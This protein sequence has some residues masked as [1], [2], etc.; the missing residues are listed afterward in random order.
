MRL[1]FSEKRT[2]ESLQ[3]MT[4]LTELLSA[5][6]D[7]DAGYLRDALQELSKRHA[8][9]DIQVNEQFEAEFEPLLTEF[10]FL[11]ETRRR[12]ATN[13]TISPPKLGQPNT[14]ARTIV[15][16]FIPSTLICLAIVAIATLS[17]TTYV[18]SFAQKILAE[19]VAGSEPVKTL[20]SNSGN[21]NDQSDHADHIEK[22]EF[23]GV[24]TTAADKQAVDDSVQKAVGPQ[25]DVKVASADIRLADGDETLSLAQQYR[26]KAVAAYQV[27]DLRLALTYFDL[28]V[29]QEPEI[30]DG[31]VDRAIVYFRLGDLKRAFADIDRAK[32]ID[33]AK[34]MTGRW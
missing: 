18:K 11:S 10:A 3:Q 17:Q 14:L 27:A 16:A 2:K 23:D 26:R 13:R 15:S 24:E 29:Q 8:A 9:G 33:A 7:D 19:I 6:P 20:S 4:G 30:S 31:Y 32:M 12:L 1:R 22:S 28:E 21:Q 5:L 25:E 34:E